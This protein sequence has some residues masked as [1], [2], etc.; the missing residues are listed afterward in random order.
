MAACVAGEK[1]ET[2]EKNKRKRLDKRQETL[3]DVGG[4]VSVPGKQTPEWRGYLQPNP[5]IACCP[6]V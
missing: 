3:P 1:E 2:A 4:S 5:I 6:G